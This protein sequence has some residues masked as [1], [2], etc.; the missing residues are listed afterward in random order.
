MGDPAPTDDWEVQSD[1]SDEFDVPPEDDLDMFD[2]LHAAREAAWQQRFRDHDL[3]GWNPK[4]PLHS[5]SKRWREGI[6]DAGNLTDRV[7]AVMNAMHS[8]ELDLPTFLY[9]VSGCLDSMMSPTDKAKVSGERG[10]L[11]GHPDFPLIL[12]AWDQH[13]ART[14]RQRQDKKNYV[15]D[16][17]VQCVKRHIS[18]EMVVL[19]PSMKMNA[20]EVSPD[21][22]LA[23]NMHEMMTET[24][25]KAP[26][27]WAIM[28]HTAETRRQARRNIVKKPHG[29]SLNWWPISMKY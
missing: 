11:L 4:N 6:A 16:A 3:K 2:V 12:E 18:K 13:A 26:V 7:L 8:L 17:A 9:A 27:L 25:E 5:R 22:L 19:K 10:L 24:E 21:A 29:V 15:K 14:V 20:Q 23:I 1:G 28:S